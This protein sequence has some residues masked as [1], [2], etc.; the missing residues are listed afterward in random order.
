[1]RTF[2]LLVGLAVVAGVSGIVMSRAHSQRVQSAPA[3]P[4]ARWVK[5]N[6]QWVEKAEV[7]AVTAE[8]QK[9]APPAGGKK[10]PP[11]GVVDQ[12]DGDAVVWQVTG[13]Y[14]TTPEEARH[15]ANALAQ[16]EVVS[17][18]R[19]QGMELR[20]VPPVPYVSQ[21]LVQNTRLEDNDFQGSVGK[22]YRTVLE[23]RLTPELRN[24]IALYDR[25]YRAQGRMAGTARLVAGLVALLAALAGYLRL[26]DMTKGYYTNWLRVAA[27]FL[28][29]AAVILMLS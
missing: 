27:G 28:G 19:A 12:K 8:P 14:Q 29:A 15:S 24:E 6:G 16:A 10:L 17:H 5:V 26:E 23:V 25:E 9:P 13:S 4:P 7:T 18:F 1:M 11:G 3:A 21:R 20:W 2:S 22:M